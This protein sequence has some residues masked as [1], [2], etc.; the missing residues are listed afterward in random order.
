VTEPE[1]ISNEA[2]YEAV[3]G[4]S[5]QLG[6]VAEIARR[7]ESNSS[8]ALNRVAAVEEQLNPST[9]PPKDGGAS[10][11]GVV[12]LNGPR[13]PAKIAKRISTAEDSV[14]QLTADVAQMKTILANQERRAGIA[15]DAASLV[16]KA[17]TFL[18]SRE[19]LNF[20]IRMGM[21]IALGY[22]AFQAK[23]AADK[24]EHAH[25]PPAMVAP[26]P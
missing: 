10:S 6:E 23:L 26:T 8:E 18:N 19:G 21:L 4:V 7:A 25:A 15:D 9:P 22:G 20:V 14:V 11:G 16:S 24:A 3:K 1:A 5:K 2:I 17:Y 13:P 12:L